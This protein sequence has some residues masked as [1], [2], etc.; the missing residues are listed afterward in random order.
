MNN[1]MKLVLVPLMLRLALKFATGIDLFKY[2]FA[3]KCY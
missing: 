1:V 3:K 2:F